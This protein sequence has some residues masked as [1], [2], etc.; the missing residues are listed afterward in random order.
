MLPQRA[1]GPEMHCRCSWMLR[2]EAKPCISYASSLP[3]R[4]E[5]GL[6]LDDARIAVSERNALECQAEAGDANGI[7]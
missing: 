6:R 5:S 4:L 3:M 7:V 1:C 2:E